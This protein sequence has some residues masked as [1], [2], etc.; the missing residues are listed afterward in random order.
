MSLPTGVDPGQ[1][2]YPNQPFNMSTF[3]GTL[4]PFPVG[5][6]T[7]LHQLTGDVPS[8]TTNTVTPNPLPGVTAPAIA[9]PS[10]S[11]VTIAADT[12]SGFVSASDQLGLPTGA[13]DA[14]PTAST[15]STI[16]DWIA[17]V[18]P[19]APVLTNPALAV[20]TTVAA[21]ATGAANPLGGITQNTW[22]TIVLVL[23]AAFLI[24]A[25]I[26]PHAATVVKLTRE[27]GEGAA[28]AA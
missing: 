5:D 13:V 15:G 17:K 9:P 11:P 1:A 2:G 25:A 6:P 8:V 12:G 22:I 28:V 20:P 21:G 14:A 16:A 7:I 23:V 19:W 18:A 10:I 26:W 4:P 24:I 3:L 27:A